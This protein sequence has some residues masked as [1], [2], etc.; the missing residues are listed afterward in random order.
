MQQKYAQVLF[1][2]EKGIEENPATAT[3][4]SQ[5]LAVSYNNLGSAQQQQGNLEEAATFFKK[6]IQVNP[7]LAPS[8]L[9]RIHYNV[10][11]VLKAQNKLD[12]ARI[13]LQKSVELDAN[14]TQ[15]VSELA[16]T[17]YTLHTQQQDYQFSQDWFSHNLLIWEQFFIPVERTGKSTSFRNW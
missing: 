2:C 14:L 4:V 1:L 16:Y 3:Q 13:Y 8:D 6:A 11:S 9:A 5:F 10:A 15:A 17:Q 7:N 12:E